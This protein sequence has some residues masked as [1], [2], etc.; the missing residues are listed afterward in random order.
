MSTVL[1][2]DDD[3]TARGSV[4]AVF[5]GEAYDLQLAK[6]GMQALQLLEQIQ[7]ASIAK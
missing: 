1:I 4:V 3:R 7:L 6:D 2:V 5:E